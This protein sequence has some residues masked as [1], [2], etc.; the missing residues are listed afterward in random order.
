MGSNRVIVTVSHPPFHNVTATT[1]QLLLA[2][3]IKRN[4]EARYKTTA[5]S[6]ILEHPAFSVCRAEGIKYFM[7]SSTKS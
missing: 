7:C 4:P 3:H 1:A 2:I 5:C 6:N